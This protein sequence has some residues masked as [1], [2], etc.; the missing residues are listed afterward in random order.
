MNTTELKNKFEAFRTNPTTIK[1]MELGGQI[2]K[3]AAVGVAIKVT[4]FILV[5][6]T[7]ALIA[8]INNQVNK[9]ND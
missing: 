2:L 9:S 6:G 3:A 4:S 5:A 7:K 8:E 1:T